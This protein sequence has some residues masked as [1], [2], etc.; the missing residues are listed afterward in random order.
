MNSS[1]FSL[2]SKRLPASLVY[3]E[4]VS[5][6]VDQPFFVVAPDKKGSN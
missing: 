1:R 5:L 2:R 6:S 4:A 3:D